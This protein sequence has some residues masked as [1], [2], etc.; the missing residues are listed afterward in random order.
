MRGVVQITRLIFKNEIQR[1]EWGVHQSLTELTDWFKKA[2]IRINVN[3]LT[4]W[5]ANWQ[6]YTI[7]AFVFRKYGR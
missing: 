3:K 7:F 5:F 1:F 2:E 4:K 6:M